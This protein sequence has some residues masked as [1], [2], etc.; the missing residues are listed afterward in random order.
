MKKFLVIL[1]ASISCLGIYNSVSAQQSMVEY[2]GVSFI[3]PVGWKVS[4][5]KDEG[6]SQTITVEK[7]GFNSSGILII[8]LF[9]EEYELNELLQNYKNGLKEQSVYSNLKFQI[10]TEG[11]Y[12]QYKGLVC[13]YTASVLFLPHKGSIHVFNTKGKSVMIL[14]QEATEDSETNK[15]GFKKMTESLTVK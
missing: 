1:I 14:Q 10:S 2:Y 7:K 11:T 9:N 12:G 3:C 5:V 4:D 6:Y 13:K 15:H 8:T